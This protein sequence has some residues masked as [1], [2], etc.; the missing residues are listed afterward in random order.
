MRGRVVPNIFKRISEVITANIND[1]IDR[2]EDPE[3]MIKQMIRELED[4]VAQARENIIEV[5]VGEKRLHEALRDHTRQSQEWLQRVEEAIQ[6]GRKDLA[7]TAV[8]HKKAHDDMIRMCEPAWEAAK[9]TSERL[10]TQLSAVQ[11]KLREAKHIQTVL[12]TKQR[13][14]QARQNMEDTLAKLHGFSSSALSAQV[15]NTFSQA[16]EKI[17]IMETR[18]KVIAEMTNIDSWPEQ[19]FLAGEWERAI[20]NE[21]AEIEMKV[22]ER[23]LSRQEQPLIPEAPHAS[24]GNRSPEE[25]E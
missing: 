4:K 17:K 1:L 12:A 5:S 7:R 6:A 2:V 21:L 14:A 13:A 22:Q 25:N 11:E 16:V 10:K 3:R 24:S 19:D 8:R 18:A 15:Q 9:K 20:E 23:L